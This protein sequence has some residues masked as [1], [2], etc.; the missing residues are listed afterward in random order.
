[1]RRACVGPGGRPTGGT[2]GARSSS[3]AGL[4]GSI[5][6]DL[7][8]RI[9]VDNTADGNGYGAWTLHENGRLDFAG[10][11]DGQWIDEDRRPGLRRLPHG[12]LDRARAEP[13]PGPRSFSPATAV[14]MFPEVVCGPT[15]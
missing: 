1:M 11:V 14:P 10:R 2:A 9:P 4:T 5:T 15:G 7:A 6:R 3:R 8:D 13:P 12:P